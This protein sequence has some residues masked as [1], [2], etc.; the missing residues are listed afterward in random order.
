MEQ[1]TPRLLEQEEYVTRAAALL[2]QRYL[3][4]QPLAAVHT[5]GCQQNV[6]DSERL[7]GLLSA[8]GFGF[9]E[10]D[11]AADL[12]LFNTCAVREH[13]EDRVFGNIGALKHLKR[14]KPGLMIGICGCMAQQQ[15][16]PRGVLHCFSGSAEMAKQVLS[17]GI[18]ILMLTQFYVKYFCC[19]Y[20]LV[21]NRINNCSMTNFVF[22]VLTN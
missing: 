6:S 14:R 12:I 18:F 1:K 9:T 15:F 10:Q 13:A 4:R 21:Y 2:K 22:I 11:E 17:L 8:M 3:G 19:I 5:Y 7:K 16:K 20:V